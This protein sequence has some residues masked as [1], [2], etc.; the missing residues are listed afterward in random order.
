MTHTHVPLPL[1]VLLG[2]HLIGIAAFCWIAG[3][4]DG[5]SELPPIFE[6]FGR[7]AVAIF[8][9][10]FAGCVL[11]IFSSRRALADLVSRSL[12]CAWILTALMAVPSLVSIVVE[13]SKSSSATPG[14][15]PLKDAI[16]S[17]AIGELRARGTPITVEVLRE[18]VPAFR[19]LSDLEIARRSHPV[20]A[21]DMDFADFAIRLGVAQGDLR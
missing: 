18:Q 10:L 5:Q 19:N 20:I 21:P 11:N 1:R 7:Y 15:R 2:R 9:G 14:T 12:L 3:Y 4:V 6:F 8:G 17:P 16:P 13:P